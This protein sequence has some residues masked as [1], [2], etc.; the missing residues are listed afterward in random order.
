MIV[1]VYKTSFDERDPDQEVKLYIGDASASRPV[2]MTDREREDVG[3]AVFSAVS[4]ARR[5]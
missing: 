5:R 1:L 2:E 4:A 3:R